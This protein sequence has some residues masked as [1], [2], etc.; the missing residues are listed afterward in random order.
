MLV[1]R[2]VGIPREVP[3]PQMTLMLAVASVTSHNMDILTL[4]ILF[5]YDVIAWA[6]WDASDLDSCWIPFSEIQKQVLGSP[7]VVTSP[8]AQCQCL[9]VHHRTST[10]SP[11]DWHYSTFANCRVSIVEP[12]TFSPFF[13][14]K[15]ED[16]GFW[17]SLFD[18]LVD[19][20]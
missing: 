14:V 16:I 5:P 18:L 2:I 15:G 13:A 12:S 11:V 8:V 20:L 17:W 9:A 19:L 4:L 7:A 10:P 3:L 1:A 6:M